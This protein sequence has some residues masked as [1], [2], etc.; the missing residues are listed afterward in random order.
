M[1]ALGNL[2]VAWEAELVGEL[3]NIYARLF[4]ADGAP[5]TGEFR[6]SA[7]VAGAQKAPDVA[8]QGTGEFLVVWE[9]FGQD[10]DQTGVYGQRFTALGAAS[11]PEFR[12]N[13]GTV[14]S[15]LEPSVGLAAD[16]T[17]VVAF[18][19]VARGVLGRAFAADGSTF[20]GDFCINEPSP[21]DRGHPSIAVAGDADFVVAWESD[22][23]DGSGFGNRARLFAGNFLFRDGSE[24]ANT[25]AWTAT[26]P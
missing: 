20:G 11:G 8:R 10:G 4:D 9:S 3:H 24:S 19:D 18:R 23:Q 25:A 2:V 14:D 15:Q 6:V 12:V 26:V 21:L 7:T 16:G 17:A 5:L 22:G 1:D 13:L